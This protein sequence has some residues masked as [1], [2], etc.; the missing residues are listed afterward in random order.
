MRFTTSTLRSAMRFLALW[1][2]AIV[3]VLATLGIMERQRLVRELTVK[4]EGLHRLA[5]QRADQHDAHLTALSAILV[6]SEEARQDLLIEVAATITRFYPRIVSVNALSLEPARPDIQTPFALGAQDA[7]RVRDLALQST[8]ALQIAPSTVDA[9]RYLLVKRSPNSQAARYALALNINAAALVASDDPFWQSPSV[10]HRLLSPQG[11]VLTG[12]LATGDATFSRAIGSASQPLILETA[13][14]I[15]TADLL[16]I[17]TVLVATALAT[18]LFWLVALGLKQRARRK[19]AEQRADLSALETRLAHASRINAMGE[20][21]SGMAHELAQPLTA[22]LSQAQAGR[23]L[24]QRGD[25]EGLARVLDD[26]VAQ[27]QRG[28]DILERLQRWSRPNRD[29]VQACSLNEAALRVKRLLGT[30]AQAKGAVVTLDLPN[31]PLQVKADPVEL[32]Q[33]IFNLVRN[34]LDAADR[35]R[36]LLRARRLGDRAVLEVSDDGPG[37]PADIRERVFEPFVTGKKDG[38]GLGL[39][40]CQRLVEEMGGD[41]EL[42]SGTAHTTFRLSLPIAAS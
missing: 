28:A 25:V 41:I 36:V 42:V 10:S 30:E 38:T 9:D 11:D 31:T 22:I 21:A 19:E 35:A 27:A 3:M 5:S 37:V 29:Q 34:A 20:M 40:L 8:G 39:A 4:S 23:H 16:P 13:L 24:V 18:L 32:E 33:V 14:R 2:C 6:A 15:R 26:T 17:G 1:A 7:T 12:G